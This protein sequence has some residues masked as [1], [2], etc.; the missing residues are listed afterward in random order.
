MHRL[1]TMSHQAK[2]AT[3]S[4][5]RSITLEDGLIYWSAGDVVSF[6]C[7][8]KYTQKQLFRLFEGHDKGSEILSKKHRFPG[9]KNPVPVITA[10]Q[11]LELRGYIPRKRLV[12]NGPENP[13]KGFVYAGYSE[14]NGTKVGMTMQDDPM[15]RLRDGN[16]YVKNPYVLLDC[17]RCDDPATLEKYIHVELDKYKVG[18]HNKELFQLPEDF[19]LES[20]FY[21]I[22]KELKR[23]NEVSQHMV[24][25]AHL[26]AYV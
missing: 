12:Y 24:S 5:T 20:F 26:G 16:T 9:T 23:G 18:E 25:D 15:K 11:G 14:G 8:R 10:A 4:P 1:S 19:L 2:H 21:F 13:K 17:I 7:G 22:K 6:L 3:Q